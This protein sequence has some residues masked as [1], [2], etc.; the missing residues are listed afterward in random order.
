MTKQEAI[1]KAQ[2]DR[3][4]V[5]ADWRKANYHWT[6]ADKQKAKA[7]LLQADDDM[8]KAL[9]MPDDEVTPGRS[10]RPLRRSEL[11]GSRPTPTG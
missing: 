11:T 5:Y 8:R 9:E 6:N 1:E 3:W 2:A 10:K 7:D 4:K